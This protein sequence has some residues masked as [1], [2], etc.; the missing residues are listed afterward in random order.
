MNDSQNLD[1]EIIPI[2]TVRESD[3]L[4]LSSRNAYLSPVE[5]QAATV[6]YRA[7]GAARNLWL[8]GER[9]GNELRGTLANK[10][11]EE[12]L[13]TIDYVSIA[14]VDSFEELDRVLGES[15]ALV[16]VKIGTTRLIDNL[17]LS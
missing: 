10:I 15:R 11:N 14:D 7:L 16:A 17:L 6:L 3:G 8:A 1:V 12:P 5:R 9:G 2:P 13:A 4:A